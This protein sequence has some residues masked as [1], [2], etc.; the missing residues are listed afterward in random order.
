MEIGARVARGEALAG[1]E[2]LGVAVVVGASGQKPP[3]SIVTF[4]SVR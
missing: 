2:P 4:S 1:A 3:P